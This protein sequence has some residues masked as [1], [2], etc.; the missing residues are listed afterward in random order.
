MAHRHE[1]SSHG[2]TRRDFI[3]KTATATAALSAAGVF[4]TGAFAQGRGAK[5][6]LVTDDADRLV[7]EPPV[8]W[9]LEQLQ[10]RL[11]ARDVSVEL[12]PGCG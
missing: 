1:N 8:R 6:A 10:D 5:V 11:K 9:A 7:K 4:T 12:H 3:K 2:E